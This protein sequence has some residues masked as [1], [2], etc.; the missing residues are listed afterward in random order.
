ML[1]IRQHMTRNLSSEM[2]NMISSLQEKISPKSPA[3]M[4]L[5]EC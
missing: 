1:A 3:L 5:S 4:D 2:L